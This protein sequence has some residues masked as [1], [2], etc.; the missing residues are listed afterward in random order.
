MFCLSTK[1]THYCH[2][3][4]MCNIK[5]TDS[6]FS[7]A[8]PTV[9]CSPTHFATI[10]IRFYYGRRK[11][12]GIFYRYN[13]FFHFVSIDKRPAIGSQPNLACR[14]EV[15]SIY[16]CPT[17]ISGAS[18]KNLVSKNITFSITFLATSAFD[19]AYL[20]NKT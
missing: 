3:H 14:S 8:R 1:Q 13:F 6:S 2:Q 17:I 10:L 9:R 20:K 18:P 19:N 11:Q 4:Q 15:V 5:M 16:K 12:D 7:V